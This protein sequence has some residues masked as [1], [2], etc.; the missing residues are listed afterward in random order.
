MNFKLF[1]S[2][3][4]LDISGLLAIGIST[5]LQTDYMRNSVYSFLL[6]SVPIGI[7]SKN[8]DVIR[9]VFLSAFKFHII[10]YFIQFNEQ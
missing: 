8:Y 6:I 2:V 9:A 3:Y 5:V 10:F 1:H 7:L 4:S